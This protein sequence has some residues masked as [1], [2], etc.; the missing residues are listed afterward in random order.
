MDHFW[1]TGS[2]EQAL[3]A[4]GVELE[5]S[6]RFDNESTPSIS[7]D[8]AKANG[9]LHAQVKING[10]W[11]DG[12][13]AATKNVSMFSAG[14]KMGKNAITSGW[15]HYYKFPFAHSVEFTAALV[16]KPGSQVKPGACATVYTLVRGYETNT[17]ITLPSGFVVPLGARMELQKTD[18]VAGPGAFTPLANL[19]KG[20]EGLLYQVAIGLTAS[21]PWGT[22]VNGKVSPHLPCAFIS[23]TSHILSLSLPLPLPLSF[24]KLHILTLL[25]SSKCKT[26]TSRAA[27]TCYEILQKHFLDKYLAQG[28]R[29]SLI[30]HTA[31]H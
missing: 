25:F 17:G 19:S 23:H 9:Q 24:H 31:S 7:F 27:G 10:T 6:Y 15:Y 4:M 21:P 30:L 8:A 26:T 5:F 2:S 1:T 16:P 3:A 12:T 18:I 13:A 22:E 20:R 28:S 14:E 11:V 29:I